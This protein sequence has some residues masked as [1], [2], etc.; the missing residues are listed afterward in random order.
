MLKEIPLLRAPEKSRTG[1]EIKPNVKYPDHTEAAISSP[2]TRERRQSLR[3]RREFN[4]TAAS[5]MQEPMADESKEKAR[6]GGLARRSPQVMVVTSWI[7]G[8]AGT[9]IRSRNPL[10]N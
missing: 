2:R 1:M 8:N 3:Q 5:W 4:L 9:A 10:C 7:R 6:P